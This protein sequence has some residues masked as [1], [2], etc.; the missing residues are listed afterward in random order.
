MKRVAIIA[1]IVAA[2]SLAAPQSASAQLEFSGEKPRIFSIQ[3]RPYRLG[4][5]FTLGLGVLPI[6]AFYVGAVASA[7]YTYHFS[8]F[9]S[10]EIASGNY[11]LNFGS[12]LRRH[13]LNDFG[14]VPERGGGERIQVFATTSIVVKPLFGKLSIFNSQVIYS[15][16][17]FV[18]G[19]G[20][21][22]KGV[23]G[24]NSWRPGV[25]LGGGLRF[26][27]GQALSWRLDIRDYLIFTDVIPENALFI[28]ISAS[29]NYFT[30][31]ERE[32]VQWPD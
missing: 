2:G 17:F 19:I 24:S 10:W 8:D 14:V 25:G 26:W 16:T 7:S 32:G 28:N 22:L 18:A 27:S 30:A 20:P 6:D 13:L 15:E 23:G 3:R 29:F 21:V 1:V 5:E 11:S 31:D 12:G 9:W 4:H